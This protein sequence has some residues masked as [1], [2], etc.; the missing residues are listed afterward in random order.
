MPNPKLEEM[1][2]SD[3]SGSRNSMAEVLA[4]GFIDDNVLGCI[5]KAHDEF[6]GAFLCDCAELMSKAVS[7]LM[8]A[9]NME[10]R[11]KL[12]QNKQY[13]QAKGE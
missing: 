8:A 4:R 2:L 10:L 9:S 7:S 13:L 3:I 11:R 5:H 1:L 12:A 6:G